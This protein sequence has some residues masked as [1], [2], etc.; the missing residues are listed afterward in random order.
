MHWFRG[1]SGVVLG[2][3]LIKPILEAGERLPVGRRDTELGPYPTRLWSV[4]VTRTVA[5]RPW[6]HERDTIWN[7]TEAEMRFEMVRPLMTLEEARLTRPVFNAYGVVVSGGCLE[8]NM[9]K[10]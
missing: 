2:G 9:E 6:P 10:R 8:F 5:G 1:R 4:R 7:V 3:I